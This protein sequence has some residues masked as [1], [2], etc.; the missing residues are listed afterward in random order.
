MDSQVSP[1][2]S[3]IIRILAMEA[4]LGEIIARPHLGTI[5]S[6]TVVGIT[7]SAVTDMYGLNVKPDVAILFA[8]ELGSLDPPRLLLYILNLNSRIIMLIFSKDVNSSTPDLS[9]ITFYSEMGGSRSY[10]LTV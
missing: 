5:T 1:I 3:S 6:T 2:H 7:N 8:I 4:D 9:D 10:T